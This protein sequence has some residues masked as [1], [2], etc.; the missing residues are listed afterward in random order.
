[1][2][3]DKYCPDPRLFETHGEWEI[4]ASNAHYIW[5]FFVGIALISAVALIIYGK[6]LSRIDDKKQ[7][8]N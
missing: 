5:Y 2:L 1:V 7:I 3:L 4:A 8:S 6:V